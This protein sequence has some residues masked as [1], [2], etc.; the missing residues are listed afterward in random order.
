MKIGLVCCQGL[1]TKILSVKMR[2]AAIDKGVDVEVVAVG[3]RSLQDSHKLKKFDCILLGPQVNYLLE[4][5]EDLGD[6][7]VPIGVIDSADFGF[8]DGDAVLE[9][10]LNLISSSSR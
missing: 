7:R 1:S 5:L 6:R 8:M 3:C 10:A 2:K 9:Q 4:E